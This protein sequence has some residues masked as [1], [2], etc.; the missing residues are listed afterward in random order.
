MLFYLCF[1][2][3]PN[4]AC[5]VALVNCILLEAFGRP[6]DPPVHVDDRVALFFF[7]ASSVFLPSIR[8]QRDVSDD[9]L[10]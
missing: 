8:L 10:Y 2:F 6:K 7:M 4:L 5:A 1:V 3:S 9:L